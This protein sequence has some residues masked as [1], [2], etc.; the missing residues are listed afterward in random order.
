MR[1]HLGAIFDLTYLA[2]MTNVLLALALL[3]LLLALFNP[4]FLVA[5]PLV[6]P[7][8]CAAFAV[9]AAHP[10]PVIGTFA[11]TWRSSFRRATTAG[12]LTTLALLV[13]GVDVRA[14]WGHPAGALL[15][16]VLVV[17][18][19]LVTA[20][21]LVSLVALA[22]CPDARLRDVLRATIFSVVRRWYLTLPSLAVLVLFEA[23]F[24][25]EPVLALA[26]A[27]SPLLYVIWANSRYTLTPVLRP[28]ERIL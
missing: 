26:L 18:I 28:T 20:T 15:I 3:P 6:A 2:L 23:L 17:L 16:P 27:A 21:T 11:R 1:R 13:L 8:L 25:A 4:V 12:T 10:G 7:G 19:V 9:F 24:A 22:E 5:S 14:A